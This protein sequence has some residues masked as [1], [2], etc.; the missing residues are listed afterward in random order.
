M[1]TE[2]YKIAIDMGKSLY[3]FLVSWECEICEIKCGCELLDCHWKFRDF[4]RIG[5][6]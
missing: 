3:I 4:L 1:K 5:C 6:D 2:T